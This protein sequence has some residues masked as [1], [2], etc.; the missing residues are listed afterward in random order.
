MTQ[1]N[2]EARDLLSA[3]E[4]TSLRAALLKVNEEFA[5]ARRD[6]IRLHELAAIATS[7][8]SKYIFIVENLGWHPHSKATDTKRLQ[9]ENLIEQ[10]LLKKRLRDI[11]ARSDDDRIIGKLQREIIAMRT[12]YRLFARLKSA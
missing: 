5:A 12:T 9:D 8:V 4:A 1:M 11:E 10:E 3:K 7:Q 6:C 2:G